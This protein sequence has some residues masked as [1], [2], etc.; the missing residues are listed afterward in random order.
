MYFSRFVHALLAVSLFHV[1]TTL[2]GHDDHHKI[3]FY[4]RNL[5]TISSIYNLT[6]FPNNVPVLTQGGAAVPPGLFAANATGRISPVG[7]FTG[8]ED[9]IEYFFALAPVPA[10]PAYFVITSSKIMSFSSGCPEVAASVVYLETRVNNTKGPYLS[11]LKQVAFWRFDD[12]GAVTSYEAWIPNLADWI[13]TVSGADY[14]NQYVQAGTIQGLCPQIQQHCVGANQQYTD[15]NSCV[16]ALSAKPFGVWDEAWTDSVVC[17]WIH[18]VLT[19]VRPDVHCPH[20]G[21]TGG[22][23]CVNEP[24]NEGYFDDATLFGLPEGDA[25]ICPQKKKHHYK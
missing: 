24:Y 20:V 5:N 16:A 10:P 17:R 4:E 13:S 1:R 19:Q 9:S 8:F 14:S 25:F 12:K 3:D 22:M 6:I 21:P 23:K 18:T 2:A 11:T 15:V 7:N